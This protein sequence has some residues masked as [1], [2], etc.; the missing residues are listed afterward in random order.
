MVDSIHYRSL[1]SSMLGGFV[2]VVIRRLLVAGTAVACAGAAFPAVASFAGP[3]PK[4]VRVAAEGTPVPGQYIVTLKQGAS[5]STEA[6]HVRAKNVQRFDGVLNAFA[7]KLNGDQLAKLRRSNK[8]AAIEQDQVVKIA[9][10]QHAP[11]PWGLD[12]IDQRNRPLSRSYTY[13]SRGAGVRAYVIDTGI[14]A[15]HPQ[16]GGR[17]RSV[18]A[19]PRFR[20]NGY[21]QNGH[22][23]HVAG[24]IGA[25]TFGA[26]KNVQIHSLRVLDRFGEGSMGD[27]LAAVRWL[28]QH[29]RKPA[30]ANLSVSG[31]RSDALNTAVATLA[32]SGVFVSVAA[33]N[34]NEVDRGYDACRFSPSGAPSVM[35]VGA[36][37]AGDA[38]TPWSNFGRCVDIFAPG[39]DILSTWPGGRTRTLSG[40]SMATPYVSGVAALF[41]STHRGARF[42]QIERWLVANSTKGKV[43][44]LPAGTPNRLLFKSGL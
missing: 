6:E 2:R 44:R 20:G 3:D 16:F 17:A 10:T 39:N 34:G 9:Q 32:R 28:R 7:A 4:P 18:W 42:P 25:R 15:N 11:L 23:T 36:T 8:V 21:D 33:G 13:K 26:A 40:T 43:R 5:T 22:G 35:T 38:R 12:R 31:D 37:T 27:V 14:A 29:A 24:I 1:L 41:L 30:V 19:A